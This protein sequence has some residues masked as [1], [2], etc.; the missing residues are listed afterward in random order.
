MATLGLR[1][2]SSGAQAG[3]ET[4][5]DLRRSAS[6]RHA[7][8]QQR[9]RKELAGNLRHHR[10]AQGQLRASGSPSRLEDRGSLP[11]AAI[12]HGEGIS[13]GDG[14]VPALVSADEAGEDRGAV[15]QG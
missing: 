14:K 7:T 15:K 13:R 3:F 10:L 12:E 1:P 2:P 11:V 4:D 9:A 5:S 6:T 8:N